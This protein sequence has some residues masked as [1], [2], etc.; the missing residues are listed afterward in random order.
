MASVPVRYGLAYPTVSSSLILLRDPKLGENKSDIEEFFHHKRDVKV[1][2][3]KKYARFVENDLT[4]HKKND[5]CG[6]ARVATYRLDI[7]PLI[8]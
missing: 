8:L 2:F 3:V 4:V 5:S 6:G 1:C 7:Q